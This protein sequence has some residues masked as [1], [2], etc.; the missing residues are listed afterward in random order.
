MPAYHVSA[1][2]DVQG[3]YLV[4]YPGPGQ[5]YLALEAAVQALGDGDIDVALAG[6]VAHQRNFLAERHHRRIDPP[7]APERLRDGA[8][9]LVLERGDAAGA[10]ARAWLEEYAILYRPHNPFEEAPAPS[11]TPESAFGPASLPMALCAAGGELAH[12]L[13]ARD[14]ICGASRWGKA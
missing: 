12:T 1:N 9:F 10:R 13:R 4:T 6:G 3:P 8:A 11:E 2:F 7:V 14:G 5:F